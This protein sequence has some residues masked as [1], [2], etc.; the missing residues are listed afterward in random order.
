MRARL[1][2]AALML[3]LCA[4]VSAQQIHV[5]GAGAQISGTPTTG[6]CAKWANS[7][8]I[9][10][11]GGT[12]GGGGNSV[13]YV[14]TSVA[15]GDTLTQACTGTG[16]DFASGS[17]TF[18][19]GTFCPSV[20]TVYTI[21]ASGVATTTGTG[22]NIGEALYIAGQQV[23]TA[24]SFVN[25]STANL[26]WS[27][28]VKVICDTTG[29]TGTAEISYLGTIETATSSNNGANVNTNPPNTAAF[30]IDTTGAVK[31]E[32]RAYFATAT[33]SSTERQVIITTP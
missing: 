17:Y 6:N 28:T 9:E 23:G 29:A 20:G 15:A 12:C 14:Q 7:T 27:I 21:F 4:V 25:A 16:C 31:I 13:K 18:S 33:G 10:D 24:Q 26:P 32:S 22:G 8:T 3:G 11:S 5:T 2:V 1:T 19:A 30:T